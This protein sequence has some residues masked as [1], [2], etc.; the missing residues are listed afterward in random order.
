M[1]GV[2]PYHLGMEDS[3]KATGILFF[4][5]NAMEVALSPLPH[6]TYRTIG[7]IL[8]FFIFMGPTVEEVTQVYTGYLGRPALFP[9]WS[10]GFQLCRYGYNSLE[11]VMEVVEENRAYGIPYDRV[12]KYFYSGFIALKKF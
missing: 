10:L 8:D 2:Q 6:V 12:L 11:A 1:Y 9:Y 7:G 5:S 3:G 4:N